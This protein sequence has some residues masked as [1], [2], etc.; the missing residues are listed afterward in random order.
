MI[1]TGKLRYEWLITGTSDD[2]N[3]TLL[4]TIEPKK[5]K[6]GSVQGSLRVNQQ[7]GGLSCSN[8][9]WYPDWKNLKGVREGTFFLSLMDDG[10]YFIARYEG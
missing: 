3:R 6:K 5:V 7:L 10:T 8:W 4:G 2:E 1:V 9:G